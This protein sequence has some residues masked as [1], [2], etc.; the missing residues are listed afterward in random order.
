MRVTAAADGCGRPATMVSAEH[1]LDGRGG[2]A[3]HF[4]KDAK[5]WIMESYYRRMRVRTRLLLDADGAR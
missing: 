3:A 1:F 4:Q 5:R 2:V